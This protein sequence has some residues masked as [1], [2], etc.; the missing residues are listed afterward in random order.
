MDKAMEQDKQISGN[1]VPGGAV[2]GKVKGKVKELAQ[3]FIG[4]GLLRC[5]V[6]A[7]KARVTKTQ[8]EEMENGNIIVTR[9]VCCLGKNRHTYPMKEI[10]AAKNKTKSE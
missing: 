6:C 5:R 9:Q 8:K 3:R 10:I 4:A 1:G 2:A 7:Q